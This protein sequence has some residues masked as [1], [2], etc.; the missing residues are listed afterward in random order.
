MEHDLAPA[1]DAFPAGHVKHTL[2]DVAPAVDEY[3]PAGQFIHALADVAPLVV[4]YVP[5]LH[6]IQ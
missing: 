2:A 1:L 4:K 3:V 6:W 5:A